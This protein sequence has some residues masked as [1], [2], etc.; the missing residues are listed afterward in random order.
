[1]SSAS[2][3]ERPGIADPELDSSL[4]GLWDRKLRCEAR[5]HSTDTRGHDPEA[6]AS[7]RGTA[8]CGQTM[9]ICSKFAEELSAHGTVAIPCQCGKRHFISSFSF[10]KI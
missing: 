4:D 2:T 10:V 5:N 6:P 8:P 1:M 3:L 7:V 9:N